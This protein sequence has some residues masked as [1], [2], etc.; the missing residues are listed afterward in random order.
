MALSS[1]YSGLADKTSLSPSNDYI[2]TP[3]KMAPES[4]VKI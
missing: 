3:R 1:R 4:T 2:A